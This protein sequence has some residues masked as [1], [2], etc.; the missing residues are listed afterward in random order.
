MARK[1]III[2]VYC[3]AE[4]G[5]VKDRRPVHEEYV[6]S[7]HFADDQLLHTPGIP[8]SLGIA[9]GLTPAMELSQ[10][11]PRFLRQTSG[12]CYIC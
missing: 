10:K 9:F 5:F 6:D 4:Y 8:L 1:R 2:R 7:T 12:F 3:C 11:W